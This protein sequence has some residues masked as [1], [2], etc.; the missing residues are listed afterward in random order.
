MAARLVSMGDARR[1][2]DGRRK[3]ARRVRTPWEEGDGA[4]SAGRDLGH[5]ERGCCSAASGVEVD[6]NLRGG[7]GHGSLAIASGGGGGE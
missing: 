2:D 7:G 3:R 6:D 1:T 5:S 4:A